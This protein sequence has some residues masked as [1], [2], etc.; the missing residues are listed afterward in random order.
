MKF[1]LSFCLLLFCLFAI[2]QTKTVYVPEAKWQIELPQLDSFSTGRVDSMM[3]RTEQTINATYDVSYDL[4]SNV[5]TYFMVKGKGFNMFNC[6]VS[7]YDSSEHSSWD[8]SYLSTVILLKDI[9]KKQAPNI[10]L[11]D[12][13]ST[14]VLIDSVTFREFTVETFYPQ[15]DVTLNVIWL[16]AN[17]GAYDMSLNI[18]YTDEEWKDFCLELIA[19]SKFLE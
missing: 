17:F 15:M 19:Q 13:K 3:S 6:Q 9:V 18:S 11:V 10:Q 14:T 7:A 12:S 16:C 8:S 5:T 1:C 2:A 4:T